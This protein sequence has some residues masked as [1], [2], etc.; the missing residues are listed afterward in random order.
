LEWRAKLDL[1]REPE[2][3]A[4]VGNE[5]FRDRFLLW[6]AT[7]ESGAAT[8]EPPPDDEVDVFADAATSYVATAACELAIIPI[9]DV[10]A[11]EEQPNLP[12]TMSDQHPN[13]R[14]RLPASADQLLE[15]PRVAARLAAI[16]EARK[17]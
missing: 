8:G 15:G 13:W 7:R 11:L 1:A 3:Q 4:Q 9:E 17:R 10:L 14:R 12:G 16:N 6:N 5:R 2:K